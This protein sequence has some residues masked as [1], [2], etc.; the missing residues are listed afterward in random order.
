MNEFNSLLRTFTPH[1]L[2]PILEIIESVLI[3]LNTEAPDTYLS[4]SKKLVE[5][6]SV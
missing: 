3:K 2:Y 4:R 1:S 6:N 5:K